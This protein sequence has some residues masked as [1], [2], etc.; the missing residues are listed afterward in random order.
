MKVNNVQS[1]AISN[2]TPRPAVLEKHVFLPDNG[3]GGDFSEQVLKFPKDWK[4]Y[5]KVLKLLEFLV[6]TDQCL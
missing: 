4:I 2:Q 5:S 3:K 1:V 6:Y